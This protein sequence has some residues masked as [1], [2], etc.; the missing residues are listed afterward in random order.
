MN[1]EERT[2]VRERQRLLKRLAGLSLL[3][4]GSYLERFS[5]CARPQC[6]CHRG[7]RH[8]PRAYVAVYRDKR[9]RQAY[10]PKAEQDAVRRGLLQ[11]RQLEEI[12]QAVTDINLRLMRTGQLGASEAQTPERIKRDE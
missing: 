7:S 8:G 1:K 2:L 11:H 3:L 5:T 6:Q 4:H 9:Q 12:V 10:V